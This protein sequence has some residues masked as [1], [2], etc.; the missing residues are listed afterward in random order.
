MTGHV[1]ADGNIPIRSA[2]QQVYGLKYRPDLEDD[3]PLNEISTEHDEYGHKDKYH[4]AS[5]YF[6][7]QLLKG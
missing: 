6:V 1:I 4:Y 3:N 7:R 5:N 2:N